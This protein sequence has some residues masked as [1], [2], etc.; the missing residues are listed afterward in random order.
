MKTMKNSYIKN[1]YDYRYG[2]LNL[3][4]TKNSEDS[5]LMTYVGHTI[6]QVTI[7][8]IKNIFIFLKRH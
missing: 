6:A 4:Q 5:S 1:S 7:L 8:D 2:P 3:N